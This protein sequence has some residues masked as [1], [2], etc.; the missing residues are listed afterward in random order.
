M[1]YVQYTV[2]NCKEKPHKSSLLLH[3]MF[4]FS[5]EIE[6]ETRPQSRGIILNNRYSKII[7]VGNWNNR[8]HKLSMII[9]MTKLKILGAELFYLF[10]CAAGVF[11]VFSARAREMRKSQTAL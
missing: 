1:L 9:I 6:Q 5:F 8:F 3:S 10:T 7:Y 11:W 4:L 2:S